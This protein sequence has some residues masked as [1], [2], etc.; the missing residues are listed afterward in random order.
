MLLKQQGILEMLDW[1]ENYQQMISGADNSYEQ[2]TADPS[3]VSF[4]F[5]KVGSCWT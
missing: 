4:R 2:Y 1:M 5:K 3:K